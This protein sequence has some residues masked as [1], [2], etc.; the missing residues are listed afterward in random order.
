MRTLKKSIEAAKVEHRPWSEELCELLRNYRATPHCTTGRPPATVLNNRP[1]RAK[2]PE[3]P[4][5]KRDPASIGRRDA[6]GKSKMKKF[7]DN[8]AWVKPSN[9]S[10]GDKV[11]VKRDPSHKK[12][13]APYDTE[14]YIVTQHKGTMIT[15]KREGK[16][17]TRNSSFFK[18]V[19]PSIPTNAE[20]T[21]DELASSTP[22][23]ATGKNPEPPSPGRRYPLRSSRRPP[24][25]LKDFV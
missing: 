9:L 6:L 23:V 25:H 2:L 8:K 20:Q 21:D 17:I 14:T 18:K 4:S 22:D 16:E 12:S 3:A 15:A 11:I 19:D 10:E 1:I 13:S 24:S 5:D 7:A